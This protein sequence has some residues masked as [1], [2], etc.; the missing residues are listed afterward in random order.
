MLVKK[1]VRYISILASTF[2]FLTAC[3]SQAK[4]DAK[5]AFTQYFTENYEVDSTKAF[6]RMYLADMTHDGAEE[7]IVV[8]QGYI[9]KGEDRTLGAG[10][11]DVLFQNE[12]G[13]VT[14]IW[15]YPIHH[16]ESTFLYLTKI[17]GEQYLLQYF[18][19]ESQGICTYH[20]NVFSLNN[21]GEAVVLKEAEADTWKS[22]SMTAEELRTQAEG[23][24][25]QAEA[26]LNQPYVLVEQGSKIPA[27]CT[28]NE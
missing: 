1:S 13:D 23:F 18:P 2:F 21:K 28:I 19:T 12:E 5:E 14:K 4:P 24:W 11:V 22:D 3:S 17:E 10:S 20:Y 26:D 8:N 6:S 25:Q 7:M 16:A 15:T 27:I 9:T